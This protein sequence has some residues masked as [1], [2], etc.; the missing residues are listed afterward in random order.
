[1][2]GIQEI[3]SKGT[4]SM[5]ACTS[6]LSIDT[7]RAP[8][9]IDITDRVWEVVRDAQVQTG[10]VVVF[11]QHTT[12]AIKI[13]ENEPLL[14]HDMEEFLEKI[15]A[16]DGYY[17]HNDFSVRT[18][19][20]TEDECPNGHAHCPAPDSGLQRDDPHRWREDALWPMAA[21]VPGRAGPASNQRGGRPGP[22]AVNP[23]AKASGF[24]PPSCKA[25]T[26]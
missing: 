13:S 17:Q 19:N 23:Q 16:R 11:S 10:F 12:A 4:A 24:L 2:A 14:L 26:P 9:F 1:M 21:P 3:T 18:V 7:V 8:Q 20:M 5:R 15:A 25:H 22:G 6:S